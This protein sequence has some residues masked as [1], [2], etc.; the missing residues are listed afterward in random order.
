MS[1]APD[2]S[3]A[4]E[5]AAAWDRAL[6]SPEDA[7]APDRE[8][9]ALA[10]YVSAGLKK[11]RGSLVRCAW[12]PEGKAVPVSDALAAWLRLARERER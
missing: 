4:A 1:T 10:V 12:N 6:A 7:A 11:R 2:L 8:R 9:L 5:L 3:Y